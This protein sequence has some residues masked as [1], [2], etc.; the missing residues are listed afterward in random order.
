MAFAAGDVDGDGIQDMAVVN[1]GDSTVSVY[2]S[3]SGG[4][5]TDDPTETAPLPRSYRGSFR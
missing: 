3:R 4:A 1:I 2:S 5:G